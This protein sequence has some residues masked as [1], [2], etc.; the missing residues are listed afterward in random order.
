MSGGSFNWLYAKDLSEAVGC[1]DWIDIKGSLNGD[2]SPEA[3]ILLCK[4]DALKRK[5]KELQAE[6]DTLGSALHDWEWYVSGD[7]SR[8][9]ALEAIRKVVQV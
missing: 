5:M 4:L 9:Q 1:Q 2:P 3:T 6:W 7:Y 8:E